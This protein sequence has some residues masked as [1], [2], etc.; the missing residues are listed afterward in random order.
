M[1]RNGRNGTQIAAK[2][3]LPRLP[4]RWI[5]GK[6]ANMAVMAACGATKLT[7]FLV[8]SGTN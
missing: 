6:T 1:S 5:R 2:A 3:V 4:S 8:G 7:G